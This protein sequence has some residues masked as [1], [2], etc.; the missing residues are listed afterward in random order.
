MLMGK[1]QD[2]LD[3]MIGKIKAKM[4]WVS[5]KSKH[6]I[7]YTTYNG[8]HDDRNAENPSC[9]ATDGINW[10]T[11]GFWGG[12]MWLMYHE[13][14]NVKYREIA[15]VSEALMDRCFQEYYGLHHDVGFMWLL[16]SVANYK[17]TGNP[18][19]CKRALHAANLLA[20]RFNVA[21]EFIRA[22]NEVD[23]HD[24]RGWAIIDC[25]LN[26][27]LLYWATEETTDPRFK[28]IAMKHADTAMAAFV[29]PDG[30]VNHIVE[31][32]P[33]QGGVVKT[34]G[35]QG[36][37]EGSSWTRGQAWGLYGF[38]L[39]YIHTGKQEYLD[40]AK[41]IGHYFMANIPAD[42]V[43]PVDFRQPEQPKLEDDTAAVIAACGLIET[44]RAVPPLEKPV[45]LERA[46]KLM[47]A[48]D[49]RSNW[50]ENSDAIVQK[51]SAAYH[52]PY[53]HYP[54]I[55][56]DYYLMEAVFKLKGNDLNLW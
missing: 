17:V 37:G 48:V 11:N 20:G 46:L 8:T 25:M 12:M 49:A 1:E 47:K 7:P 13:T 45:Y 18:E 28:Q 16:T 31:F 30:S 54:I 44:A 21:G 41:R 4:E 2:W 3:R 38:M 5:E 22:W 53:H 19:S 52:A 26:L 32:D 42:G 6:K 51:G 29:R 15:G 14:G 39:S 55:Y 34:H 35:G 10:W 33:F 9:T 56:G 24:T 40:T 23:G 27:P 43:I 36:Y 50:L